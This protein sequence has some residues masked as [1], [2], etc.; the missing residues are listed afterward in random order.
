MQVRLLKD[1]IDK[2]SVE[3]ITEH[4]LPLLEPLARDSVELIRVELCSVFA[5]IVKI[6]AEKNIED[7]CGI[8]DEIILPLLWRM[9]TEHCNTVLPCPRCH[10]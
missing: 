6:Y 4:I 10:V 7:G 8:A 1:V 5:K 9:V 2:Y 3:V